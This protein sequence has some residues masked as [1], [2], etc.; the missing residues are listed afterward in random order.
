MTG[1][2]STVLAE[3]LVF[4]SSELQLS[5]HTV[6][7]YRRDLSRLLGTESE[8]PDR[9]RILEHIAGL[10]KSHAPASV[11]RAMAAVRGFFRFLCAE[12]LVETD[13]TEGLLGARLEQS[14]PR[15]LGR[16]SIEKPPG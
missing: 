5:A 6:A 12:S 8:L 10:R 11:A 1:R 15:V 14:L 2:T 9:A 16:K 3:F 13:P 7:A 4:L